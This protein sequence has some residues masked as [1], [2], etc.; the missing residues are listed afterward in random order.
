MDN[1]LKK[2]RIRLSS[3]KKN[4][5][6]GNFLILSFL[7]LLWINFSLVSAYLALTKF[8]SATLDYGEK[9][10][11]NI[12]FI[13]PAKSPLVCG[14]AQQTGGIPIENITIFVRHYNND[15][16]IAQNKS[17]N[18]GRFCIT[19]PEINKSTKF[20]FYV[21]YDNATLILGSNDYQMNFKN[22]L[23]YDRNTNRYIAL[24]GNITNGDAPVESGRFEVKMGQKISGQWKY[25]YGDYQNYYIN[26]PSND[27]YTF[28]SEELNFSQDISELD[29]G[30]YKLL[31]KTSFNGKEYSG[32][33]KCS[34]LFNITG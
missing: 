11:L 4:M 9:Y 17:G 6:L 28:P 1:S 19:L 20:D 2:G 12:P 15:T 10:T 24:S 5:K 27:I 34:V 32:C 31:I 30:E 23:V 18:D 29:N 16:T 14:K 22:N 25:I 21:E 3:L 33:S 8:G 13:G 26:I 7:V